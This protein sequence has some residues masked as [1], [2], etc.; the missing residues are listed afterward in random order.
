METSRRLDCLSDGAA[1]S[2]DAQRQHRDVRGRPVAAPRR[3]G[4]PR[5]AATSRA[6][7]S[8]ALDVRG[9]DTIRARRRR[10]EEARELLRRAVVHQRG[11]AK[12][13]A[14]RVVACEWVSSAGPWTRDSAR[15]RSAP[16]PR[17]RRGPPS[18]GEAPVTKG[19][20]QSNTDVVAAASIRAPLQAL[21]SDDIL[22]LATETLDAYGW[23]RFDKFLG[24]KPAH[25]LSGEDAHE[26]RN[27]TRQNTFRFGEKYA[28]TDKDRDEVSKIDRLDEALF[29][30][31]V[32]R[33]RPSRDRAAADWS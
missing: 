30:A 13:Q 16:W 4:T 19:G 6:P 17:R 15:G 25:G 3:P 12:G 1:T 31:A 11:A 23:Q 14:A 22:V 32:D 18:R 29:S 2:T 10:L 24:L 5:G 28:P 7:R 8:V 27:R 9:R 26:G 20:N 21:S 33:K